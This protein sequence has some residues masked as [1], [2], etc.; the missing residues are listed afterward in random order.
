[1][2]E[3]QQTLRRLSQLCRRD[4]FALGQFYTWERRASQR[5]RESLRAGE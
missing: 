5:P 1:M 2:R 4:G 3:G